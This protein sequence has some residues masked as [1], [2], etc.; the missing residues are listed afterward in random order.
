[1]TG[2][3]DGGLCTWTLDTGPGSNEIRGSVY[4]ASGGFVRSQPVIF[5][6][7]NDTDA[8]VARL[9]TGSLVAW[10]DPDTN[11]GDI[12]FRIFNAAGTGP[13]VIITANTATAGLQSGPS[14]AASPF[15]AEFA[16][17][18]QDEN[19]L[20][21]KARLF[22]AAGSEFAPEFVVAASDASQSSSAPVVAWLNNG[23]FAVAWH[24]V[25]FLT[26]D[27]QIRA[28]I[29]GGQTATA[30]ALSGKIPVN[31]TISASSKVQRSRRFPTAGSSSA[32]RTRNRWRQSAGHPAAEPSTERATRSAAR[33]WSTRRRRR[34]GQPSIRRSPTAACVVGRRQA[35]ALTISACRSSIRATASSPARRG[36]DTLYGHDAVDDE[37]TGFDGD[38][39][40]RGLRGDDQLYGGGGNDD[41]YGGQD[42]DVLYGGA[43]ADALLGE[44]GDDDLFGEDGNDDLRGGAGAD[45]LDGGAGSDTANYGDLDHRRDR[46]ARRLAGGDRRGGRRHLYLGRVP[47]GLELGSSGDTLRGDG[48][49]NSIFGNAGNDNLNGMAGHDKLI[50]GLGT[51]TMAGG[52]GNDQFIYN[53]LDRDARRAHRLHV[54]RRRQQRRVPVQGIG[55]RRPAGRRDHCGAVPVLD[56]GDALPTATSASSTRPTRASC[57][58][59]PTAR[60]AAARRSS[61]PRCRSAR[62]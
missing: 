25:N 7:G 38:D 34:S 27:V 56:G 14:V 32:G 18:W 11:S 13:A 19:A 48:G 26:N 47:Q 37:I 8:E 50:G 62:R 16:I 29:F 1:M 28:K 9:G 52:T 35:P 2:L 31:S 23:E 39:I 30:I 59:T 46:G 53:L 3:A 22:N 57:A 61:S 21:I 49:A 12:N 17:V 58:S 33:F 41:L 43:G 10:E 42:G 60:A 55:L 15:G 24:E 36:A 45:N 6:V 51:D 44:A 4:N 20:S 54:Q 40:L 5:A